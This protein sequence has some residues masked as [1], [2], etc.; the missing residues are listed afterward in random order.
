VDI[1]VTGAK[2]LFEIP[3]LGG[4]KIS[5]TLVNTWLVMIVLTGLCIWLTRDL[6]VILIDEPTVGIDI[7]AKDEIYNIIEELASQGV[8]VLMVSS[9][10]A[11]V[12]RV[13]HRII[14]MREGRIIKEFNHGVATQEDILLTSSG[15]VSEEEAA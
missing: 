9:D 3:V 1:S 12:L 2:I 15:F 8:A 6:K 13:A 14:V 11:E 4:I 10:I 7:G 5:E